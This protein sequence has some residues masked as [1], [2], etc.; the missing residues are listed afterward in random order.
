MSFL[1][2][3]VIPESRCRTLLDFR[4]VGFEN[5]RR[6]K[7][8]NATV[9]ISARAIDDAW[10]RTDFFDI[11]AVVIDHELKNEIAAS[12][13]RQ[14][15]ITPNLNENAAPEALVMELTNLFNRGSE[16]VQ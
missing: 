13:F 14:P 15:F 11:G 3:T 16:S 10:A 12:A 1:F 5:G 6:S 8:F 7:V 4:R 9:T 2:S